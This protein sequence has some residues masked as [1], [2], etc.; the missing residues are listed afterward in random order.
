M[1][2]V[3]KA[4]NAAEVNACSGRSTFEWQIVERH[5]AVILWS[6]LRKYTEPVLRVGN[7]VNCAH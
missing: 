3:R 2:I 6:A 1:Q 5:H 7:M 4:T